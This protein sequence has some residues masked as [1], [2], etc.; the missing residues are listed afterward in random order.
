V[1]YAAAHHY[2]PN[3]ASFQDFDP[4]WEFVGGPLHS[5][6]FGPNELDRTF[7]PEVKFVKAPKPGIVNESPMAGGQYFGE[8]EIDGK[9]AAMTVHL[10]EING[11]SLWST[12]LAPQRG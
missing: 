5:G 2:H 10:R 11:A 6:S 12:T 3:R 8:V 1:H 7:G 9:T 4:F